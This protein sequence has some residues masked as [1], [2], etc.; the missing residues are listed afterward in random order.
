MATYVIALGAVI[1][2][3]A[4][5]GT[6]LSNLIFGKGSDKVTAII[7]QELLV[8]SN[9]NSILSILMITTISVVT[10]AFAI[11]TAYSIAKKLRKRCVK[12]QDVEKGKNGDSNVETTAV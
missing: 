9:K 4:F 8:N 2:A 6:S 3:A 7:K 11:G 5:L 10:A 1:G 12:K